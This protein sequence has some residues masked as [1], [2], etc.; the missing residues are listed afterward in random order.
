M[1]SPARP[2]DR[3]SPLPLWAQVLDDLK[4]RLEVGEFDHGFP[5][6]RELIEEY[7][8]SRHTV[9]DA[10]TRLRQAGV[11]SR[12]RG[13]GTFLRRATI[14]QPTGALYS[15]FRSIED[16]GFTARSVV[17]ELRRTSD[18]V[19]AERLGVGPADG[20]VYL[21]R[22]RLAGDTPIAADEVWL[23]GALAAPLLDADFEHSSVYGELEAR[24]GIRPRSGWERVSPVLPS[25]DERR[26]LGIGARQP[27]FLVERLT[28]A[29]GRPLEWRRTVIRGD[30]YAF[31]TTWG[32][33]GEDAARVMMMSGGSTAA[34]L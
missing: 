20:L 23:P 22:L 26:L 27:V 30:E 10:M 1:P 33:T 13:R 2:L 25:E 4:R 16:R 3:T 17:L 8:V 19:V 29:G 9:R 11:I 6:E 31:V 12:E 28:E 32:V 34:A 5:P 14:E 18:A 24:C 21:R 7:G 15:L